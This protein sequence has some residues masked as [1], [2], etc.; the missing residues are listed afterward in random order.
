MPNLY[1]RRHLLISDLLL[2]LL[3]TVTAAT[4]L[5]RVSVESTGYLSPDSLA[6]LKMAQNIKD[7]QGF[8]ILNA[9][10]VGRHYFSTWPVG[11]PVLIYLFSELS[12]LDVYWASKAMNLLLLAAGFLLLRH[13][14]RPYAYLLAS[15]YGA[16]TFMEV[17]SFTWSEAP[18]LLISL[19]LVY[20]SHQVLLE[21]KT[22]RNI[23]LIFLCCLSLLLIRYIGAF[24]FAVPGLLGL[25]F[26]FIHKYRIAAKLIAVAIFL[27]ICAGSYLYTNYVLSGFTTGFDRMEAETE[28]LSAFAGM[29]SEGILNEFLLIRK[30][31]AGNQPDYLLYVTALLQLS[32]LAFIV[33]KVK[34]H[35]RWREHFS[36]T[37]FPF[38]CLSVA[39]FYLIAVMLLRSFSHFDD[40]DY[41]LLAPCSFLFWIGLVHALVSLPDSSRSVTQAKHVAFAFFV[42]SLLL[43]LPKQF[44]IEKA[45]LLFQ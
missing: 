3:Y 1:N 10:G 28:T 4:I 6:Y 9:D 29:V 24:S 42:F 33:V 36:R 14:N 8:Y 11:Y 34:R 35:S 25:Y 18:F 45:M 37:S 23:L 17:Y 43:N 40:L 31:R 22:N 2:L 20:V 21:R 27:A 39:F 44:I 41:R 7:G 13:L 5:F 16:Y 15:V 26:G 38:V 30:F 19:V 12:S 32:A